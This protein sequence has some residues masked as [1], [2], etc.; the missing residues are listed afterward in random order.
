[1]AGVSDIKLI[2]ECGAAH[3]RAARIENDRV[4]RLW[5]G[6]ARGDEKLDRT[7]RVGRR[8][9]GK[10]LSVDKRLDAAFVD[11]GHAAPGLL[12]LIK[13]TQPNEGVIVMV[14]VTREPRGDKG[15]SLALVESEN[16]PAQIGPL[17]D[18]PDAVVQAYQ[19]LGGD[20]NEVIAD[21]GDA[22]SLLGGAVCL[23]A[24]VTHFHDRNGLFASFGADI[25]LSEALSRSVDLPNGG[26]MTVDETE[27]LTAIDI[28]TGG[29][30]ASSSQRLNE[31]IN[32]EAAE[33]A[34]RQLSLRNIG[35]QIAIDFLP[36]HGSARTKLNDKLKFLFPNAQ[37]ASWTKTGL[38]VFSRPRAERSLLEHTTE[39]AI[40]EPV[41]GRRFTLDWQAKQAMTELERRLRASPSSRLRLVAG[42]GITSYL[43][44]WPQWL[45]RLRE[46]YGARFDLGADAKLE[47][48][49]F[50]I[51]EQR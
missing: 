49:A 17:E 46:R 25:A 11:I 30:Q 34:A 7:P 26:E 40:T 45:A 3:T 51:V 20:A 36:L 44:Y 21:A 24:S 48:R 27:A 39:N 23:N 15:A 10:I 8:Y 2:I 16:T 38:F 14:V 19:A 9:G 5:F 41:S 50:D 29:L 1:M 42:E 32:S 37:Y 6:P 13:T 33:A 12:S 31:R 4:A 28:D 47:E 35:G 22:I 18:T 43:D